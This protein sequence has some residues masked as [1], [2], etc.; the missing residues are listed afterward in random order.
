M[1]FKLA[2]FLSLVIHWIVGIF[3]FLIGTFALFLPWSSFLQRFTLEWIHENTLILS[4]F[5]LSFI[6]IG[7][8]IGLYT[9]LQTGQ[10]VLSI[11]IGNKAISV[12]EEVIR[13]YL[14]DYWHS[15]FPNAPISYTLQIKKKE[16]Q[17]LADFP[18]LPLSEQKSFLE[19]INADLTDLFERIIGY[20][21][22]VHLLIHFQN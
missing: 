5:G 3:F 13:H 2:H 12:D 15:Y 21:Q 14:D 18:S 8:S 10:H 9:A 22:T 17:I 7:L 1:N 4:L 11:R 16:I 19:K 6:L 20:P